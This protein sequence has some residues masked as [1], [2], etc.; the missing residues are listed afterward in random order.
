MNKTT[1]DWPGLT[2]TFNPVSGCKRNCCKKSHGF[3]CYAKKLH[4]KRHKAF[5]KGKNLPGRYRYP[6]NEL[7]FYPDTL[8][9]QP[10]KS[11]VVKRVFI[12][13]MSDICYWK[14]YWVEDV[15][16]FCKD[17]PLIEFMFLTK[18][19][20]VYSKHRFPDNCYLGVTINSGKDFYKVALLRGVT[21][22]WFDSTFVSI[23]PLLGNF[24]G[25]DFKDIDLVIVGADTTPGA[26][27]PLKEWIDAI[28]ENETIERLYWKNNIRKYL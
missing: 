27:P 6:F 3:D 4:T 14:D 2:H 18:D 9:K 5:K 28:Q 17:R 24:G 13:S 12:G 1:I 23:E 16:K 10:R 21:I 20:H 26:T 8:N 7:M 19:P 25:F 22:S 11:N 15:I